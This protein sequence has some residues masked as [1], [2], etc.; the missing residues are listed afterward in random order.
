MSGQMPSYTPLP[1]TLTAGTTPGHSA[2]HEKLNAMYNALGDMHYYGTGFPNGVV[3]APVGSI[4]IDTAVTNGA[5]SWI[6]KSGTGNTGWQVLEG[7]TGRRNITSLCANVT[8]GN[9]YLM[10]DG[11]IV[12]FALADVVLGTESGT[13][14]ITPS[15]ASFAPSWSSFNGAALA[16]STT[17]KRFQHSTGDSRVYSIISGDTLNGQFMWTT[18]GSWPTTLPGTV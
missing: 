16:G 17:V 13:V 7:N 8:S 9:V 12:T 18:K 10:R 2:H 4:Y 3:T 14:V 1:T 5:S 6:K 11:N 15:I